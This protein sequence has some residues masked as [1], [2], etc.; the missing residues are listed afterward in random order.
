[1]RVLGFDIG[2]T[3]SAVILA[4]KI[5]GKIVFHDRIEIQTT[6]DWKKV[7]DELI[8]EG[9]N[10]LQRFGK[11]NEEYKIGIS[12]GGPLDGKNGIILSPPNLSGWD[13]VPIV[14]YIYNRLGVKPKLQNDADACALAEWKYGAGKGYENI[15]F[16]TFGTGLGAGL[17][18]NGQLYTGANNMAGEVGHIRL[19]SEGPIGYGKH[20]SFEGF[21]SGGGIAQIAK[22]KAYS[23][24]KQG[25]KAS[26]IKLDAED[27][28]TK[29]VA[30]AAR[31]GH[32]DALDVFRLS[33][34][35]F[36][37]GLSILID[38]LNPELII[39]GSIYA[40]VGRFLNDSMYREIE[41]EALESSRRAVKIVPAQLGEQIG[42]YG[43]VV[44]ALA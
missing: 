5:D 7:I 37:K 44:T 11:D 26:Y 43:A 14:D 10:M 8:E 23:L 12:C 18:L 42:D 28:T 31:E 17:I 29:D 9:S 40:R 15:I 6:R 36:G 30:E 38:I 20:G 3:K 13:N 41:R 1:M 25:L 39:V 34:E 27:I 24:E 2:G 19:S 33:G 16:L 35:Y 32:E 4:K 22:E 21:C